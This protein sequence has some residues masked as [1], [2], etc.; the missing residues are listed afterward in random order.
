MVS[1][2]FPDR[3]NW[4]RRRGE[5]RRRDSEEKLCLGKVVA[6]TQHGPFR[7][8]TRR[9]TALQ[10]LSR[11]SRV[12]ACVH[13]SKHICTDAHAHG[14]S[15]ACCSSPS[16]HL[17]LT[18]F[19]QVASR[20]S[21]GLCVPLPLSLLFSPFSLSHS[22]SMCKGNFGDKYRDGAEEWGR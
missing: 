2:S 22:L 18:K 6:L 21:V 20:V 19:R 14:L 16:A 13:V 10:V 4:G 8:G 12:C 3:R 9:G 15:R 7:R 17:Q 11:P 1:I 5:W